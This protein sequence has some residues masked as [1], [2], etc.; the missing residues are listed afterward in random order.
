[1]TIK[2]EKSITSLEQKENVMPTTTTIVKDTT[3]MSQ[4]TESFK[5]EEEE[6]VLPDN[7]GENSV[8]SPRL[9]LIAD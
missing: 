4:E 3:T 2:S 5:D 8:E 1:M 9:I 6:E 7:K